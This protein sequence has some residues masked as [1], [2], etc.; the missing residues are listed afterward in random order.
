MKAEYDKNHATKDGHGNVTA[1]NQNGVDAKGRPRKSDNKNWRF[2]DSLKNVKPK[3][4][5]DG[6]GLGITTKT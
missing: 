5:A 4:S 2:G 6:L 3:P 1:N